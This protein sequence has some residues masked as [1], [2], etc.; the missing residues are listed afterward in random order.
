MIVTAFTDPRHARARS[1][2]AAIV[3][4][5][6]SGCGFSLLMPVMALNLEDMTGS[7]FIVGLNG[8]IAALS[9][10]IAAPFVPRLLQVFPGRP[11]IIAS[12]LLGALTLVIFPAVLDV[13]LWF[14][15]RF[16]LGAFIS[17]VFVTS[18]TWINQIADPARRATILGMYAT[19]L[20][21]GF[22]AG[23]LLFAWLGHTGLAPWIAGIM[24]FCIGTL[25]V[26]F[27]RG[28]SVQPPGIEE[29]GLGAMLSAAK[30]ARLAIAAALLFGATETIFFSLVPV[31]G[32]RIDL[33]PEAVG[34]MM[35]AGALGGIAMQVPIGWLADRFGRTN[36]LLAI[37]LI[38]LLGPGIIY[39]AG[40]NAPVLYAIMFI[41]V[42]VTMSLYTVGLSLIGERFS[43]GAIAAANAAF[44]FMYGAGSLVAPLAGGAAIDWV[45]PYG[46]LIVLFAFAVCFI[47]F[48]LNEMRKRPPKPLEGS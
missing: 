13:T 47:V 4:A 34:L 19:A 11:L 17:V 39:L 33:P 14:V 2:G 28:P 40:A 43:G 1:M 5:T 15:L 32:V 22:G 18:E 37:S 30:T 24:L 38:C 45:N 20:A 26:L 10:L 21:S 44:I 35:A 36:A 29:A 46:L 7:G 25:P 27:L 41:Y 3:C 48:A 9:T 42:G 12:L 23:G 31:Y 8:M 6:L 16:A